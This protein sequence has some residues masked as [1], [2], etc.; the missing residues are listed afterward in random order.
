MQGLSQQPVLQ[1]AVDDVHIYAVV[2]RK[3]GKVIGRFD[4]AAP[5]AWT[6]VALANR[7][8]QS[9]RA[10]IAFRGVEISRADVKKRACDKPLIGAYPIYA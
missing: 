3:D 10:S 9:G 6:A 1:N 5:D 2:A 7:W 8:L 4:V